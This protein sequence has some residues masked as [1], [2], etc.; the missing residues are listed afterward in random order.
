MPTIEDRA[1]EIAEALTPAPNLARITP[2]VDNRTNCVLASGGVVVRLQQSPI[3]TYRVDGPKHDRSPVVTPA[4]IRDAIKSGACNLTLQVLPFDQVD[5]FEH[6]VPIGNHLTVI[7]KGTQA[8]VRVWKL[9][10]ENC[11]T[12]TEATQ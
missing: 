2:E 11:V 10:A 12:I 1:N 8:L 7:V 5:I 4:K 3:L 9:D 6:W